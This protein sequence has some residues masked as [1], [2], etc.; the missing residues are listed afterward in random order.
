MFGINEKFFQIKIFYT[1][2][3]TLTGVENYRNDVLE[4]VY[5]LKDYDSNIRFII[6]THPFDDIETVKKS[7]NKKWPKNFNHVSE[8]FEIFDL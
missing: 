5:K 2:L 4:L 1:I 8:K 3:V 6:K 7:F